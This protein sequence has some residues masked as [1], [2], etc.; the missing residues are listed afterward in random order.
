[1]ADFVF[2]ELAREI[3]KATGPKKQQHT[4]KPG[5]IK[6]ES[7]PVWSSEYNKNR[8][9]QKIVFPWNYAPLQVTKLCESWIQR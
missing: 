5:F 1:M 4:Q 7:V 6:K 2:P 3:S 9:E 8:K